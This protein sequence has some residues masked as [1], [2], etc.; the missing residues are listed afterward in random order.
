MGHGVLALSTCSAMAAGLQV[1]SGLMALDSLTTWAPGVRGIPTR[2][3]VCATVDAATYGNGRNDAS[4]GIQ[5]AV[6]ACPVGRG[7]P[8]I[9]GHLHGQQPYPDQQGHH[10]A[11][12]RPGANDPAEDQSERRAGTDPHCRAIALAPH[13]RDHC[14]EPHRGRRAGGDVGDGANGAGFAP[15][16]FVKLDE[17]DYTTATW[18]ALPARIGRITAQSWPPIESSGRSIIPRRQG[19]C[20]CPGVVVAQSRRT[21]ARRDQGSHRGERE[22]HHLLDASAHHLHHG[23]SRATGPVHRRELD[24]RP[25]RGRGGHDPHRRLGRQRLVLS[26]RLFVG[27]EHRVHAVR[28]SLRGH[29]AQLSTGDSRFDHSPHEPSVSG[30]APATRSACNTARRKC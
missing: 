14:R 15:G 25:Q 13:R 2:T 16:Q 3:R 11:W 20:L 21:A 26:G 1:G 17:D 19:T 5:A 22:H 6:N 30:R 28:Q 23:E 27:Q 4:A 7:R 8:A 24:P 29:H 12:R 18:M 9:G 10:A